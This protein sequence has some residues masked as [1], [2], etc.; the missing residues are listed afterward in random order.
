MVDVVFEWEKLSDSLRE[1]F[2]GVVVHAEWNCECVICRKSPIKHD[3]RLHLGIVPLD[4]AIDCQSAWYNYSAKKWSS[5][6][7]F[8]YAMKK[9]G[10]SIGVSSLQELLEKL[11]GMIFEFESITVVKYIERETGMKAPSKLPEALAKKETW[12]P[13]RVVRPNEL[14]FILREDF[15]QKIGDKI[16]MDA[17]MQ[18]A[19]EAWE[20]HLKEHEQEE[21]GI[22]E[23]TE[24]TYDFTGV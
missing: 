14:E 7:A 10:V 4:K 22:E 21:T 13:I 20:N 5:W 23:V 15:R 16:N 2:T 9:L 3:K 24:T 6:G 19:R 1:P 18:L 12:I 11:K 17:I 8:C